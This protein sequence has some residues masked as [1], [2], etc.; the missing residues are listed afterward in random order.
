[1]TPQPGKSNLF[2]D[3]GAFDML[4]ELE[5]NTPEELRRQR[6]HFRVTLKS[7][8]ILAPGNT[9]DA[10]KLKLQGVTGDLS[11]GGCRILFPLPPLVGD[12]YRLTFDRSVLDLPTTYARC[13]RCHLLR[14]DAFEAGFRFFN[15]ITLPENVALESTTA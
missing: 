9:S 6:T 5:R 4:A 1:M 3:E 7:K 12:I 13:V 14:E 2:S 8:V 15:L 10:T 11:E